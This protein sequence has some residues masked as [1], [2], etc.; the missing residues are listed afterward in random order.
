MQAQGGRTPLLKA[1]LGVQGLNGHLEVVQA[2]VKGGANVNQADKVR[3][4]LMHATW[5][6]CE[7]VESYSHG[8]HLLSAG[9]SVHIE[10]L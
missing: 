2:L 7:C 6:A 3:P 10:H 1:A 8:A 4:R 9:A 5:C